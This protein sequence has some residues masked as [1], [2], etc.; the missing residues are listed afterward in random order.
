MTPLPNA[1]KE[2]AQ[3]E[4]LVAAETAGGRRPDAERERVLRVAERLALRLGN[5]V[6]VAIIG[7]P[8]SG[9]ATLAGFLVGHDI[10]PPR[11]ASGITLP[12]IL[13]H[14]DRPVGIAGWWS[15]IEIPLHGSDLSAATEYGPD[16]VELRLPN[17]VLHHIGFLLMPG[18]PG[19]EQQK[20]QV[21][22]IAARSDV[23]IWCSAA[24]KPWIDDER[25]LWSLVPRKLQARSLLVFTRR[26]L[27]PTGEPVVEANAARSHFHQ[28]LSIATKTAIAAAPGGQ[29]TNPSAWNAAGGKGMVAAL[30]SAAR[31]VRKADI[32]SAHAAIEALRQSPAPK[33][34]PFAPDLPRH[35][36]TQPTPVVSGPPAGPVQ[37]GTTEELDTPDTVSPAAEDEAPVLPDPVAEAVVAEADPIVP[38][39]GAPAASDA[40]APLPALLATLSEGAAGLSAYVEEAGG[41]RD[42]EFMTRATELAEQISGQAVDRAV[43]RPEA[44]E[45]RGLLEDA[46]VALSLLQLES[47]ADPCRDAATALLQISRELA[48]AAAPKEAADHGG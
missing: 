40:P 23:L 43:L 4:R 34:A 27:A 38:D 6:R 17:P 22:W 5:P 42:W 19:W 12:V 10:E 29:V 32:A 8:G 28:V 7:L 39:T 37:E 31:E 9:K 26:D 25:Q 20:N 47:G 21:S 33:E 44:V 3:L 36:P 2:R 13:R 11:T 24:D 45:T 41:F 30:I 15:G 48:W 18:A 1:E 46:V 14:G 16:Y 35:A